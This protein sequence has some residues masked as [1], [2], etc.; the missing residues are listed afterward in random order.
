MSEMA[1]KENSRS[2]LALGGVQFFFTLGWTVYA[3][4]LPDLLKGA[5]I[6]VSWLPALLMADQ[7][8]FAMMDIVFGTLAD[9]VADGYRKLA[10]LLLWLTT[11]SAGLSCCC[12]CWSA[13]LP[14]CC[15][16]C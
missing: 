9:R 8:I 3:T 2:A 11:V 14:A 16:W 15:W 6:A 1:P 13:F 5:G 7:I 10:R 4:Y 12:Q